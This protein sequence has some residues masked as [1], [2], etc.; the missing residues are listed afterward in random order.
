MMVASWKHH[1]DLSDS[2]GVFKLEYYKKFTFYRVREYDEW[3]CK[4]ARETQ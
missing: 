3:L 4:E 1:A 2:F